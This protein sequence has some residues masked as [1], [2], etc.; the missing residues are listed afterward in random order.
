MTTVTPQGFTYTPLFCEE[1]IWLLARHFIAQGIDADKLTI[2]FISNS[3]QQVAVFNQC[4]GPADQPIIWDYHVI[5]LS[6]KSGHYQVYDFDSLAPFPCHIERYLAASFQPQLQ[7]ADAYQPRFRLIA[8][9]DFIRQ[10]SSDRSH[11]K[12][13]IKADSFPDYAEIIAVKESIP[14]TLY[15]YIDFRKP[16]YKNEPLL[17]ISELEKFI[18][19]TSKAVSD[20]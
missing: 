1:N 10:F 12:G 4:N 9:D 6:N 13:V 18:S 3:Q 7:I 5:L 16:L 15:E 8:A 17:T 11:M 14:V 20:Q 19:E 2:V